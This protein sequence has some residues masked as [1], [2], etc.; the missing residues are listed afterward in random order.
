MAFICLLT[1]N[2]LSALQVVI[3]QRTAVQDL[4]WD[5]KGYTLQHFLGIYR[6]R[7]MYKTKWGRKES[8]GIHTIQM[9]KC[10]VS[11]WWFQCANL[12]MRRIQKLRGSENRANYC[13]PCMGYSWG[14]HVLTQGHPAVAT[15]N[16]SLQQ[17]N[18]PCME[19]C[20]APGRH[21]GKLRDFS[22][23]LLCDSDIYQVGGSWYHFLWGSNVVVTCNVPVWTGRIIETQSGLG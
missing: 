22:L 21:L 23:T 4:N 7:K 20:R 1:G 16:S 11:A 5:P 13:F 10:W 15:A 6:H 14:V 12:L 9:Q 17:Q 8:W 18:M 19:L 2:V 3:I